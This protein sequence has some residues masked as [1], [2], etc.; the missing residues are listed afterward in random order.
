M[1]QRELSD[2]EHH[3][4]KDALDKNGSPVAAAPDAPDLATSPSCGGIVDLRGRRVGKNPDDKTWYYRH[5]RRE[6]RG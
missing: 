3:S 5:R 6:G 2:K 4:V 1:A